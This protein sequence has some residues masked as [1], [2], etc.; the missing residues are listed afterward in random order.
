MGKTKSKAPF[1]SYEM[2]TGSGKTMLMGACTYFL[3]QKFNIRN[4]LIITPASTDIYQKTIRN[5]SVGG[6]DSVWSDDTPF[7]FNLIT[8]DNYTQNLFFDNSK[9]ANIF[10]FNISKFGTNATNTNKTWESAVWQ[11]N[12]GN[13]ISVKE[14]LK[15]QK[16]I[17]HYRRS[18]PSSDSAAKKIIKQFPPNRVIRIYSD[19]IRG[20]KGSRKR[21]TNKLSIN[22]IFGGFWKRWSW[23]SW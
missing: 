23:A 15:G 11:D 4:F 16:L 14:F 20:R 3:N 10:I 22:M 7:K 18:S 17:I 13:S 21:K 2:A 5:F 19:S 6:F 9:D 12:N 8:G 1:L